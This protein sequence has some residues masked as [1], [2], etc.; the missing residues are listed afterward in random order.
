MK[1]VQMTSKFLVAALLVSGVANAG[2]T[3]TVKTALTTAK[4][5]T[6]ETFAVA[7]D[8]TVQGWTSLK[9]YAKPIQ[10]DEAAKMELR[11]EL[12]AARNLKAQLRQ[13]R[14]ANPEAVGEITRLESTIAGMAP[15]HFYS[16]LR[17]EHP[18]YVRYG[19]LAA[20]A[21]AI[22]AGIATGVAAYKHKAAIVGKMKSGANTVKA[23]MQA[24]VKAVKS[25][26]ATKSV[27]DVFTV[28]AKKAM[29]MANGKQDI[30]LE[31]DLV[32]TLTTGAVAEATKALTTA[33]QKELSGAVSSFN[34][35]IANYYVS[36]KSEESI[37]AL[38]EALIVLE[39]TVAT[40]N[41]AVKPVTKA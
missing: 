2:F 14:S 30:V 26:F 25:L 34:D 22:T 5:K 9:E 11:M 35:K 21:S 7:K 15:V 10:R 28:Q 32:G 40:C 3:D 13:V 39:K 6:Q 24:C 23:K 31:K 12:Q 33:Q 29:K 19:V 8:K 17:N 18:N 4:D 20:A 36:E 38:Q 37:K 27:F 1:T 16:D 41:Q